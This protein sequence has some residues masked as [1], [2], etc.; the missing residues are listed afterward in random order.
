MKPIIGIIMRPDKLI[1]GN[2]VMCVYEDLRMSIISSGGIPLGIMP[3]TD[4]LDDFNTDIY[5]L[6]DMC[7]GIILQG[8]DEFYNYDLECLKYIY[9][10]D[11]P[12]L[13]ICLGMQ[14]MG[15]MFSGKLENIAKHKYKDKKYV[16]KIYIDKNS[17]LYDIFKSDVISVNSRHISALDNTDLDIV[18]LSDDNVIEAIEDKNKKFFIG[19]QWHPESMYSYDILECNLFDYFIDVCRK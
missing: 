19:V 2:A 18:G 1:S 17:K 12:V 10:K 16:H 3:L 4:N 15:S 14:L 7:D 5:N 11:I 8:G 6:I 9:E 13:G